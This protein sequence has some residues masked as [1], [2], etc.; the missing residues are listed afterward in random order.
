M[1]L[2]ISSLKIKKLQPITNWNKKILYIFGNIWL[3]Y[4]WEVEKP[5]ILLM[6]FK[7]VHKK[8]GQLILILPFDKNVFI[9]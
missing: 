8:N 1:T 5:F 7:G 6:K 9:K 3:K 4:F 2:N